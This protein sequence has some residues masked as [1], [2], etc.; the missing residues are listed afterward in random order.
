VNWA[1]LAGR[2]A[3]MNGVSGGAVVGP[4]WGSIALRLAYLAA[5]AAACAWTALRAFRAY[6][7][8]V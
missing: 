7:R 2:D 5:F 3:L 1:V 6:Q 4:D 8:S